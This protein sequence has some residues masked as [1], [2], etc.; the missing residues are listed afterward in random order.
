MKLLID[1]IDLS[2]EEFN[3]FTTTFK[4]PPKV[5]LAVRNSPLYDSLPN[6]FNLQ[7]EL[8]ANGMFDLFAQYS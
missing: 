3:V 2:E 4:Y 6:N 1:S 8:N 7:L 5:Y